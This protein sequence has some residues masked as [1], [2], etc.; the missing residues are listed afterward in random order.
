M[1]VCHNTTLLTLDPAVRV[2]PGMPGVRCGTC[3]GNG[4]EVWVIPGKACHVCGS[5]C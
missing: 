1:L 4:T 2:V 5:P 3:A